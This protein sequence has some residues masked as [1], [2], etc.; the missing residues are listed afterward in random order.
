MP[1]SQMVLPSLP[2][3]VSSETKDIPKPDNLLA[4][5]NGPTQVTVHKPLE[6]E[7]SPKL[8]TPTNGYQVLET[9]TK[10]FT[11]AAAA[12]VT[13]PNESGRG[14]ALTATPNKPA[15]DPRSKSSPSV[16]LQPLAS[17]SQYLKPF[18]P[19]LMQHHLDTLRRGG[20]EIERQK[21]LKAIAQMSDWQDANGAGAVLRNIAMTDYNTHMRLSAV[22]MLGSMKNDRRMVME[23]LHISAEYDSDLTIRR[24]ATQLLD[25]L[26]SLPANEGV[27]R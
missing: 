23:A 13:T 5:A 2:E 1:T 16:P 21:A 25:R 6:N 19:V 22:Q 27:R 14:P 8:P 4:K 3:Q 24:T 10:T 9:T 20:S 15:G 26:A 17:G 18:D 12:P 11:G 7:S